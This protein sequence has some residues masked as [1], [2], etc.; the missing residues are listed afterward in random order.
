MMVLPFITIGAALIAAVRGNR[1]MSIG[2][3]F[4]SLAILLALFAYHATDP[5]DLQF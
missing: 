5:L 3:W 1:S 4:L 2:L